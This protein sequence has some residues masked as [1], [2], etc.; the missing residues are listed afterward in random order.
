MTT[1]THH[2][3]APQA[4]PIGYA[5]SGLPGGRRVGMEETLEQ[6]ALRGDERAWNALI[7]RHN[8]RVWVRLL[9]LGASPPEADDL[10]QQTWMRLTLQLRAKRLVEL[11][12]PGLALRQARFLYLSSRRGPDTLTDEL[13]PS[14]PLADDGPGVDD[15]LAHRQQ[16]ERVTASLGGVSPRARDIFVAVQTEG[17]SAAEAA[18]RFDISV[19]RVRQTLCEV[20]KVLR[21]ALESE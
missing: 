2:I 16:L 18:Q 13:D 11:I 1:T 19:Q 17:L 8:R 21:T 4:W 5:P 9:S 7:G 20:R 10:S 12:L 6:K 3:T 15:S 14:L